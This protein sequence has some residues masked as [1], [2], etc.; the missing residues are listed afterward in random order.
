MIN[1]ARGGIINEPALKEALK[2]NII[3][4]A[5]LDVYY[6]EPP[7]DIELLKLPNL[8][9]TPHTGGNSY[10]AVVSMGES[11]ISHLV[12]FVEMK[13]SFKP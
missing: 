2:K 13:N 3:A 9:S 4:G 12:K 5:A 10:E 7:I 1:T 8:I 6:P 11:A